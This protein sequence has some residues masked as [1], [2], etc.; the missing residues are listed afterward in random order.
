MGIASRSLGRKNAPQ[1][2][3]ELGDKIVARQRRHQGH[4][5]L[6]P[7]IRPDFLRWPAFGER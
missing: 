2:D 5:S 4:Q 7:T 3:P 6:L 1:L